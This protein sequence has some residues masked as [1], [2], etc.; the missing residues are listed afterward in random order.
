MAILPRSESD[1]PISVIPYGELWAVQL[2]SPPGVVIVAT[3]TE[4]EK[5]AAILKERESEV[6]SLEDDSHIQVGAWA[7]VE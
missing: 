6:T 3:Q 1:M 2:T 5:L 7:N 4:A